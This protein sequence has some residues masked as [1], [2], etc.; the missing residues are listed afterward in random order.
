MEK[1]TMDRIAGEVGGS[2]AVSENQAVLTVEPGQLVRACS[3]ISSEPGL[4][5]LST[6]TG[7]DEGEEI[8][9]MYHFWKGREF[10]TV[11]TA[12]KKDSPTVET[13]STALPSALLYE[14]EVHDMLGVVFQGNPL[15][16]K[17]L[18]LPD[19]YP[20]DAPPPLR[21]EANPEEIR[22][23]MGLE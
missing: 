10:F 11:R 15:M 8:E 4:Y 3:L 12:L 14:A 18:L 17:K 22:R 16:G 1:E 13:V 19:N 6:V 20:P 9:L 7:T 21:K 23:M 2:V 5:H